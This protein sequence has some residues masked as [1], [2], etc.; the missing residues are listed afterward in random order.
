MNLST[1]YPGGLPNFK[2]LEHINISQN[3]KMDYA[4]AFVSLGKL[5]GLHSLELS[6][7]QFDDFPASIANLQSLQKIT[8]YGL[9]IKNLDNFFANL[10]KLP[11]LS[12]LWLRGGDQ[13]CFAGIDRWFTKAGETN[14]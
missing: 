13:Y 9:R 4:N 3:P 14:P 7:C 8:G 1:S 10:S 2:K 6:Y 12:E 5:P 11:A